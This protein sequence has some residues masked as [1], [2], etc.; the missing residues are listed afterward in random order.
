[1]IALPVDKSYS[2]DDY[3]AELEVFIN[4][5]NRYTAS[6]EDQCIAYLE[7]PSS[8]SELTPE[9][10]AHC[11]AVCEK[12]KYVQ[13]QLKHYTADIARRFSGY[14]KMMVPRTELIFKVV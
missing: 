10:L 3:K 9:F 6:E 14:K 13:S 11:R 12:N 2:P 1:M 5:I 8:D 7:D 4:D